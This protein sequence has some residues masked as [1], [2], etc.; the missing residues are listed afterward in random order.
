RGFRPGGSGRV[1]SVLGGKEAQGGGGTS[2]EGE[3]R[4][5]TTRSRASRRAGPQRKGGTAAMK[6]DNRSPC[7]CIAPH[8]ER[9][10]REAEVHIRFGQVTVTLRTNLSESDLLARLSDR[11]RKVDAVFSHAD[12]LHLRG[13]NALEVRF[14]AGVSP[15]EALAILGFDST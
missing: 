13:G 1:R 6:K 8:G 5:T 14:V 10:A 4:P 9:V 2:C 7:E 11:T 15:Q 3:A 12:C